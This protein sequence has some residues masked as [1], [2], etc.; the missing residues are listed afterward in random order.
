M[1]NDVFLSEAAIRKVAPAVFAKEPSAYISDNY[2]QVRTIDVVKQLDDEGWG[3][4]YAA[5]PRTKNEMK[6]LYGKH[7]LRFRRYDAKPL[8]KVGETFP[9]VVLMNS[10]D[11]HSAYRLWAGLFRLACL[12]GMVISDSTFASL[13]LQHSE[14]L[15]EELVAGTQ[16]VISDIPL[17]TEKIQ[18]FLQIELTSAQ[19]INF[20]T[21]ALKV[22]YGDDHKSSLQ[23]SQL[24]EVRRTEDNHNDL[25]HT[26]NVVQE[27]LVVGGIEG[28]TENGRK[29]KTRGLHAIKK[30]IAVN[31]GLWELADSFNERLA[32]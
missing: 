1:K 11:G 28:K 14:T 7:C 30:N 2:S 23:A 24:L 27:N 22:A 21:R 3:V 9:E 12:N 17:L 31:T 25:W 8:T 18:S 32:A 13:N 19:R 5:Q 4:V 6:R 15:M 20:A 10:H 26:L 29:T 16:Q